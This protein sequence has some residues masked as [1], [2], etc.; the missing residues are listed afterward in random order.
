MKTIKINNKHV[1]L[2]AHRGLSGLYQENTTLSFINA[3]KGNYYGIETDVHVTKDNKFI[4]SHDD[5]IKRVSGIDLVIEESTYEELRKIKVKDKDGSYTN[6]LFLPNLEEYILIC[7]EYNKHPIL[8]LKGV[9]SYNNILD[10][11]TIIQSYNYIN[12]TTFISFHKENIEILRNMSY[13]FN[14]QFLSGIDND[15]MKKD[16]IN[17]A[18][19]N[20]V[21]VDVYY[22]NI[23]KDFINECHKN[24][25]KVNVWTVDD[26]LEAS[27][28]IDL[29]VDYITSNIL[30]EK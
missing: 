20:K 19:K 11:I 26:P 9:M 21:D 5:N 18:I 28:L 16:T 1:K 15:E 13:E 22:K 10:I 7:K 14:I 12:E 23:D 25:I 2:I 27:Y 4:I 29:G 3:G 30:E 8:E 17:F 24:N 6:N